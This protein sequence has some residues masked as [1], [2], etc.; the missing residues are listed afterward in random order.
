MLI[1]VYVFQKWRRLIIHMLRIRLATNMLVGMRP[2]LRNSFAFF[3][4]PWYRRFKEGKDSDVDTIFLVPKDYS[5][6][7]SSDKFNTPL[8]TCGEATQVYGS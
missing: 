2:G 8:F 7:R 5:K 6:A 3:P 1:V 4:T